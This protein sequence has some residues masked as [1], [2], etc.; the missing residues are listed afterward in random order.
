MS[1]TTYPNA[2]TNTTTITINN[3]IKKKKINE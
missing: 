2:A 1:K 3:N